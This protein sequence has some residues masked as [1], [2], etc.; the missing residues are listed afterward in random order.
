MTGR[1]PTPEAPSQNPDPNSPTMRRQIRE[2]PLIAAV[3]T[4]RNMTTARTRSA[5]RSRIRHHVYGIRRNLQVSDNQASRSQGRATAAV[6]HGKLS[7]EV[8][9][10][11]SLHHLHQK[12]VRAGIGSE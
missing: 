7:S 5:L 3:Q 9:V 6:M 8:K 2:E 11:I 10:A 12:R 1:L 4:C